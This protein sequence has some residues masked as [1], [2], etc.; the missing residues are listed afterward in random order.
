MSYATGHNRFTSQYLLNIYSYCRF[1]RLRVI[2]VCE[3]SMNMNKIKNQ[4]LY[5]DR[6]IHD[7]A[8]PAGKSHSPVGYKYHALHSCHVCYKTAAIS[9]TELRCTPC[10]LQLSATQNIISTEMLD[11][12]PT[13]VDKMLEEQFSSRS[14]SSK[15][16]S[17]TAA[18]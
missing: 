6:H 14:N 7:T 4:P 11:E 3:K 2:N 8:P 15:M 13:D 1:C 18:Y 5:L 17:S 10:H 12:L 9:A 16:L